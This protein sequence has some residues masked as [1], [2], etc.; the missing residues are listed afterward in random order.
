MGG[1]KR[2]RRR[3]RG[4][5]GEGGGGEKGTQTGLDCSFPVCVGLSAGE[6]NQNR[7]I[8]RVP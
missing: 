1:K 4:M 7:E 6:G 2:Q 5:N 8:R 3:K